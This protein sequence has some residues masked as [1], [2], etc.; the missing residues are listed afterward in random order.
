[1]DPPPGS[2]AAAVDGWLSLLRMGLSDPLPLS[3][4]PPNSTVGMLA[5]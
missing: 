4:K 3:D 2:V 5:R 1:M